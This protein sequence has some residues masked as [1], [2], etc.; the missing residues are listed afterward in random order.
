[1][2]QL[3]S[4]RL[5]ILDILNNYHAGT[6]I[7]R[8]YDVVSHMPMVLNLPAQKKTRNRYYL[9]LNYKQS[10]SFHVVLLERI[11]IGTKLF[12]PLVRPNV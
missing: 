5:L 1:M 10:K 9:N 11:D 6:H 7:L 2:M 12:R 3:L 8:V 4:L